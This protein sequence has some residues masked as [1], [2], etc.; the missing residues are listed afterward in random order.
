[1]KM[2][3]PAFDDEQEDLMLAA[4][5]LDSMGH[6][7]GMTATEFYASLMFSDIE[8]EKHRQVF[9]AAVALETMLVIAD[10]EGSFETVH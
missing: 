2:N 10:E 4:K 8:E 7:A 9:L 3:V 5:I 1:M 6:V